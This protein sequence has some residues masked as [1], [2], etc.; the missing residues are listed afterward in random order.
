MATPRSRTRP[1]TSEP[2][3]QPA[4]PAVRI[5]SGP[6]FELVAELAAFASGPARA[7]LESGKPWI[8]EVRAL[9]GPDLI[10]RVERWAFGL[11]G[12]LASFALETGAPH[13]PQQL[14][15]ALRA[16][17]PDVVRRRLLGAESAQNRSMVSDGAFDRGLAGD[18]AA[19]SELRVALGPN[20]PARMGVD[21]LL[22]TSSEAVQR[23]ITAIVEE[24]AW[25]VFPAFAANALAIIDRDA[26]A[27]E[28]L[29][30][31]SPAR[32]VLRISTN[33]VEFEPP[34]WVTDI[35]IVPTVALRP[36]LAP[37][38]FGTTEI[39]LCSVGDEAFDDDPAAPPRRLVKLAAALGDER[40]LRILHALAD[41]EL[42][43][44]EIADRL[45]VERTSLHH[46]LGILRSAGLV[47][48]HDDGVHGWRFARRA[49]G[50]GEVGAELAEYLGGARK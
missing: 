49:E 4:F 20:R 32:D 12:E 6:A 2:A 17:P 39:F 10:R 29:L 25:R 26:E 43:A 15:E 42:T 8:R 44:S 3:T 33:G 23:E 18:E 31:A 14:V 19:R 16:L 37:V 40:R 21:R 27:K 13:N 46:H 1:P 45:G 22:T 5:L 50:V 28:R 30:E 35:V 34:A 7:S 41:V 11:Y 47:T 24:W 36:F 48:I 9:A 38:E